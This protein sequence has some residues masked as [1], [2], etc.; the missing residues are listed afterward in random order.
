MDRESN[1]I[2][3][4]KLEGLLSWGPTK[5]KG[6]LAQRTRLGEFLGKGKGGEVLPSTKKQKDQTKA[7]TRRISVAIEV[8]LH[9][10]R[11]KSLLLLLKGI[12]LEESIANISSVHLLH[13]VHHR[14]L[15][16]R[17]L[18]RQE[19]ETDRWVVDS[20]LYLRKISSVT[21]SRLTWP[22]MP[23][24]ILKLIWKR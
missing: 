21:I 18:Q 3:K 4:M 9:P 6:K 20:K 8:L 14:H 16:P 13:L 15:L 2:L 12:N 5:I 22:N 7:S 19:I 23:M 24:H 11:Q 1:S 10:R 17:S